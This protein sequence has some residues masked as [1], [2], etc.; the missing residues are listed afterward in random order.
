MNFVITDKEILLEDIPRN[1]KHN[2]PNLH[3]IPYLA[4]SKADAVSFE[5]HWKDL[6]LINGAL[7]I[8]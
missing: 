7:P 6:S 8:F 4:L 1:A 5:L 3:K 2:H